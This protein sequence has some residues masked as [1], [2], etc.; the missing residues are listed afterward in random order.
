MRFI[1]K[2]HP[3]FVKGL[4]FILEKGTFFFAQLF[5]GHGRNVVSSKKRILFSGPDISVFGPKIRFLPFG[6]F[7]ALGDTVHFPSWGQ[8]FDF[9][10]PSYGRHYDFVDKDNDIESDFVTQL[11]IPGK[12]SN[13][14]HDIEWLTVREWSGVHSQL[15]SCLFFFCE[16]HWSVNAEAEVLFCCSEVTGTFLLTKEICWHC[17]P[18]VCYIKSHWMA[19]LFTFFV[20]FFFIQQAYSSLAQITRQDMLVCISQLREWLLF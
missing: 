13:L 2:K 10:F 14:N 8:F 9:S 20:C 18:F 15:L 5:S 7:V 3:K 4:I 11:T 6:P 17:I 12:L 1:P 16:W 19:L